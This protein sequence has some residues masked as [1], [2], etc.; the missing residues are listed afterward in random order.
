MHVTQVRESP[1]HRVRRPHLPRRRSWWLL[2]FVPALLVVLPVAAWA[3]D[4]SAG[5][6]VRGV[7][8]EGHDVGGVSEDSLPMRLGAISEEFAERP[9]EIVTPTRTYTTTAGDVGLRIDERDTGE[10]ALAVGDDT[11][12]L[13][14]PVEWVGSLFATRE[15]TPSFRVNETTVGTTLAE[16]EGR[17]RIEPIEPDVR[18]TGDGFQFV[19][20]QA[21]QG[22]D[23]EDVVPQLVPAAETAGGGP[24]RV[25]VEPRT[26]QPQR[27]DDE[28]REV[29]EEAQRLSDE[30]L[31]LRINGNRSTIQVETLREWVELPTTDSGRIQVVLDEE[32]VRQDLDDRF[33]HLEVAPSDAAFDVVDGEVR[34]I[35]S[36]TGVRCCER[37]AVEEIIDA[38]ENDRRRVVLELEPREPDLTTAE[39]EALGIVE[40]IGRPNAFGPTTEYPCCQSRVTNIHRIADIVRGA[41][42]R[43][44]ETFSVNEYVGQRTTERGFVEGGVIYQGRVTSDV[45]GGVS[46][47]ATTLFNAALFGGL[48]LT[49]YQSHSLYISRYPRGHEATISWPS[50]DL[51]VTNDT[52]Y[53]VLIWPE[54]TD[55]SL[56]VHLYSTRHQRVRVGEPTP[57]PAGP[58][59]RWTTP[60]VRRHSD[61]TRV[62]DEVS[63]LYRPREGV[64]C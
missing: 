10:A 37:G 3:I 40:E 38:L 63:A 28:I 57:E 35:P 12:L 64:N 56:T 2:V 61:G 23:V 32:A 55:T 6:V 52:D 58:C 39:A 27:E 21:G 33:Q 36:T 50:P 62:R 16:L 5:G 20:G 19:P 4:S 11:F 17:D 29:A 54:Y 42:I 25:R 31:R 1:R 47:F 49:E 45:G 8:I 14:R 13:A 18:L 34:I 9:V 44:G 7:S 43:P 26:I 60:R 15:V 53:G 22:I 51:K 59:T 46:Q 24:I 30:P 41:V 48:E